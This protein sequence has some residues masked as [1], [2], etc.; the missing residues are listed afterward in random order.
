MKRIILVFTLVV[1]ALLMSATVVFAD[2]VTWH[3]YPG[4]SIQAAVD[5]ASSGDVIVVHDGVYYESILVD[6]NDLSLV[7]DGYVSLEPTLCTSHDDVI[8]IYNAVVTVEGFDIDASSCMSGIYARGCS[9][10]GE[11]NVAV[12]IKNNHVEGYLKNGITVNCDLATGE[13][14]NNSV[15][16]SGD[17]PIYA[18][19]GIQFG[20]G[21]SGVVMDNTVDL[22]WYAGEDWTAS[23]ILVFEANDV[24]VQKNTIENSQSG[25]AVESWCWYEPTAS[26]NKIVANTIKNAKWGISV[27]AYSWEPYSQCP[28]SADNNKVVK[29]VITSE[30]GDVGVSIGAYLVAGSYEP[31]ADNNKVT[32]NLITGFD[33]DIDDTGS[34]TKV[35]ANIP[36]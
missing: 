7:A 27:S 12:H 10:L 24:M 29:N 20:Y 6:G 36:Y 25:I 8:T 19:N 28:P 16:G 21:A 4:E 31:S 2:P 32:R 22:N 35:H 3:I 1:I 18:Q 9:W 5:N 13:V 15:I 30:D 34:S 17:D 33:S 14:R 23:G 11:G 26:Y